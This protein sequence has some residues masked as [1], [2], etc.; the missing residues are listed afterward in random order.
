MGKPYIIGISSQKGGVG[1]TTISVNLSVALRSMDYNVLL[2]DSD[3]TN[4]SVGFHLGLEKANVGY[5]DVMLGKVPLQDAIAVHSVTGLN[6]LPGTL[7]SKQFNP[8]VQAIQKMGQDLAKS[9]YDYII[10]DT[11]PGFVENDL[12]MYYNEALIVTVPDMP[13]CTSSIRLARDYDNVNVNHNLVINRVKNKRY[14]IS[15]AEIEEIYGKAISEEM[16]EDEIVPVSIS[17]H[18]PAYIVKPRS[19]FSATVRKL[20]GMYISGKSGQAAPPRR[21]FSVVDFLKSLFGWK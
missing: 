9:N 17:E 14:E 6:V 16:P 20:A 3:T 21:H 2:I 5:R 15:V 1:K 18:I 10:M 4:P 13:S 7:N 8:G 12:S 19:H 11:A